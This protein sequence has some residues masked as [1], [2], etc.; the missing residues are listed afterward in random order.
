MVA[1]CDDD[2]EEDCDDDGDD[3]GD[4]DCVDDDGVDDDGVGDDGVNDDDDGWITLESTSFT[5]RFTLRGR[6]AS[7]NHDSDTKR[8]NEAVII[9]INRLA[10]DV[11]SFLS[12]HPLYPHILSIL[13]PLAYMNS[14]YLN[15][16][17]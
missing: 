3:D 5:T 11:I 13:I 17:A 7:T 4:V 16:M 15:P 9:M 2:E 6:S 1:G 14:P 8:R 12:S 10:F